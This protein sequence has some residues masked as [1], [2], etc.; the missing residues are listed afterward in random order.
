M[1]WQVREDGPH[2]CLSLI[3]VTTRTRKQ[4]K[5]NL[6]AQ[7]HSFCK[8]LSTQGGSWISETTRRRGEALSF[9][10]I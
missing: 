10:K 6:G 8:I 1:F 2:G 4:A 5:Q 3:A 9:F 7:L